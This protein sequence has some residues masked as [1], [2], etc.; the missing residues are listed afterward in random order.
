MY[1]VIVGIASSDPSSPDDYKARLPRDLGIVHIVVEVNKIAA[2][3]RA[4]H[5]P[6]MGEPGASPRSG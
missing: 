1:S 2:P 5:R 4:S 6:K 3:S